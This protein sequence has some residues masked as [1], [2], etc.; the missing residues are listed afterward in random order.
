M[1]PGEKEVG[2]LVHIAGYAL[3]AALGFHPEFH[4]VRN[5]HGIRADGTYEDSD[6]T[7]VSSE[8]FWGRD[9]KHTDVPTGFLSDDA[10]YE[11]QWYANGFPEGRIAYVGALT[12]LRPYF[13]TLWHTPGWKFRPPRTL[14]ESM[15]FVEM[16][17]SLI[18]GLFDISD[19]AVPYIGGNIQLI[20]IPLPAV[21]P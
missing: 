6:E 13:H 12:F 21:Y 2:T 20:G 18:H 15:C 17:M 11:P 19:Y 10:S 7:F 14:H 16:F 5:M 1:L 4:F 3:D 9:C 8:D